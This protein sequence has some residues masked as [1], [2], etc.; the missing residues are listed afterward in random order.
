MNN[1][2]CES[3]KQY[4]ATRIICMQG[5]DAKHSFVSYLLPLKWLYEEPLLLCSTF[6]HMVFSFRWL[7]KGKRE[8]SDNFVYIHQ[9]VLAWHISLSQSNMRCTAPLSTGVC[10]EFSF[11]IYCMQDTHWR[12]LFFFFEK[13]LIDE[14]LRSHWMHNYCF[15]LYSTQYVIHR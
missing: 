4:T 5:V 15:F 14:I 11:T 8:S 9:K 2:I 13:K 12:L 7:P 10:P 6:E 1:R 3:F